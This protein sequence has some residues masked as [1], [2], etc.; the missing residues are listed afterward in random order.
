MIEHKDMQV[1]QVCRDP[2]DFVWLVTAK[3]EDPPGVDAIQSQWKGEHERW[4]GPIPTQ[5]AVSGTCR[6]DANDPLQTGGPYAGVR[7]A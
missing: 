5:T 4:D 7:I 2:Q 3:Y 6:I 1:G